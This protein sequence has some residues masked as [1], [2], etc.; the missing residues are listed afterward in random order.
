MY[1][2]IA[3]Y[4]LLLSNRL[5]SNTAKPWLPA[6]GCAHASL[7]LRI[8]WVQCAGFDILVGFEILDIIYVAHA[9]MWQKLEGHIDKHCLL[10]CLG[11]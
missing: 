4:D 11:I 9:I 8:R 5:W 6:Y 3:G 7:F 10:A 2:P 1:C